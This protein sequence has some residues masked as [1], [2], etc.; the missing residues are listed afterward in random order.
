MNLNEIQRSS[1]RISIS[2]GLGIS[3]TYY[4]TCVHTDWFQNMDLI[5]FTVDI[6]QRKYPMIRVT[7]T[8]YTS[9]RSFSSFLPFFSTKMFHNFQRHLSLPFIKCIYL[10]FYKEYQTQSTVAYPSL[11]KYKLERFLITLQQ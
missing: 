7:S 2:I 4:F 6:I 8:N 11:Y 10:L 5:C 3:F 1:T 9:D